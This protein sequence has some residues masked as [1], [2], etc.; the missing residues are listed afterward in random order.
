MSSVTL[1]TQAGLPVA[2]AAKTE[3]PELARLFTDAKIKTAAKLCFISA[4]GCAVAT[5]TIT[6]AV[7]LAASLV[8]M[9]SIPFLYYLV[10]PAAETEGHNQTSYFTD[11]KI[12]KIISAT[13]CFAAAIGFTAAAIATVGTTAASIPSLYYLFVACASSATAAGTV[14]VCLSIAE[15]ND[16]GQTEGIKAKPHYFTDNKIRK[17]ALI[18]LAVACMVASAI[19]MP[20]SAVPFQTSLVLGWSLTGLVW[21][22][23]LAFLAFE[24]DDQDKKA[25][26]NAWEKRQDF[27]PQPQSHKVGSKIKTD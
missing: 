15:D 13:L 6:G 16:K 8:T 12:K 26:L 24:K 1:S 4:I 9:T 17:I 21:C 2:P 25:A 27:A 10:A 20:F 7:P 5:I 3:S 23:T 14:P 19:F 18:A 11:A 22:S